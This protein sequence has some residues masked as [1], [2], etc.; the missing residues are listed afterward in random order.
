MAPEPFVP[1]M[2]GSSPKYKP[3]CAMARVSSIPQNEV[4]PLRR[5]TP[6]WRGQQVQCESAFV[7]MRFLEIK[8]INRNR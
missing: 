6:Q 3:M 4:F 1:E 8:I 2:G 5:F 7:N